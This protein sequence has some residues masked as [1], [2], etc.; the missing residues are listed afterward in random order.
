L[1]LL[2]ILII[3]GWFV[4][5]FKDGDITERF[6]TVGDFGMGGWVLFFIGCVGGF[7]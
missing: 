1:I 2:T 4:D 7:T 3:I 6:W 5:E